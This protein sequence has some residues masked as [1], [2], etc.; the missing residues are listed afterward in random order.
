LADAERHHA[1]GS[2][3]H[4]GGEHRAE[5]NERARQ[6]AEHEQR[7]R[8]APRF[9]DANGLGLLGDLLRQ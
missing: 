5:G 4:R 9:L 3:Q 1:G 2:R 6:N 8:I 7:C